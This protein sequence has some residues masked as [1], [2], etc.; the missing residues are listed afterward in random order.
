MTTI[1][2]EKSLRFLFQ[3]GWRVLKYDDSSFHRNQF[4][5][6]AGGSKAVDFV[7]VSADDK[8]VWLIEVKDYRQQ[9]RAKSVSVF[10]EVAAKVRATLAGLAT[11]RV[12]ANDTDECEFADLAMH[13]SRIRVALHLEQPQKT[14]RLRPQVI[15][16]ASS[17]QKM[18]QA[19]RAVDPHAICCGHGVKEFALPW[20]VER[21]APASSG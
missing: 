9:P 12:R 18:R 4:Q 3:E 21:I 17:Y 10:D 5:A 8:E 13:G 6:F 1:L 11:A 20:T 7:A 14:S 16:P 2:D 19:M 15:D